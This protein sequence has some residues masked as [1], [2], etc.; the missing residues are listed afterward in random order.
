[1]TVNTGFAVASSAVVAIAV[2]AGL[3]LGGSPG[4]QRLVR[5]DELRVGDLQLLSSAIDRRWETFEQLPASLEDLVDGVLLKRM[6]LDPQTGT[7]YVYE[8]TGDNSYRLCTGFS[9]ASV[10]PLPGDFWAHEPGYRCFDFTLVSA[11]PEP[12]PGEAAQ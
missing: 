8:I 7:Q 1:V 3:F 4:E 6:P 10:N 11:E 12:S 9:R 5:F 2:V